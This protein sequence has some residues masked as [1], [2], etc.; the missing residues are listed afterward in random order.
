[1]KE[2]EDEA[3]FYRRH[4]GPQWKIDAA[5]DELGRT[6]FERDY[7][8]EKWEHVCDGCG[9]PERHCK[10]CNKCDSYPCECC[11]TCGYANC[12]CCSTCEDYPCSCCDEC[13]QPE[14]YCRCCTKCNSYP[15]EC[16][17]TCGY[18]DCKCCS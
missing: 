16:C 4:G 11:D 15:C 13:G 18:A 2:A 14:R 7:E 6:Q 1:M 10:C 8:D 5:D 3:Y 9:E 12:R 17:D